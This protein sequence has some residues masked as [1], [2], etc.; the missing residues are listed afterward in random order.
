M[1]FIPDSVTR[2]II[3]E[4][5]YRFATNYDHNMARKV[6]N[7]TCMDRYSNCLCKAREKAKEMA[8]SN[9]IVDLKGHGPKGI[10]TEI[11]DSLVDI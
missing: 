7:C 10:R 2:D 3:S 6:W 8:K 1:R 5:K 11:W 9:N 4:N